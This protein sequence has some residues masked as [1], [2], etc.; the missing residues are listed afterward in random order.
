MIHSRADRHARPPKCLLGCTI[1]PI[2]L[3][4]LALAT[5]GLAGGALAA[6]AF[7]DSPAVQAATPAAPPAPSEAAPPIQQPIGSQ[8]SGAQ[9]STPSFVGSAAVPATGYGQKSLL[10]Q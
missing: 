2:T 1:D 5:T 3:T 9:G 6:K 7:T 4:G 10:G 8:K